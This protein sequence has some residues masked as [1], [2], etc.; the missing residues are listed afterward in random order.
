MDHVTL[1]TSIPRTPETICANAVLVP[2]AG[3]EVPIR[4]VAEP[5]ASIS[6]DANSFRA[7]PVRST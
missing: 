4:A 5:S 7:D 6:T 2:L 3:E 1:A